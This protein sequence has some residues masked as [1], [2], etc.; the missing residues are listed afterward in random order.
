MPPGFT[1]NLRGITYCPEAAI[2]AAAQKLGPR[3]AGDARAARPR[4][5]SAPPTSPPA[6]AATPSTRSARCTWPG[7]FKGAPLSLVAITPA[8]AGPYDYGVVVVRVALHVD[9]LDRPGQRGLRHGAARSSAASRSGCA[10]SR[11]TSTSRNFTINPTNCSPVLG[12]LAGDRRPGDGHRLLAPTS[13]SST[14]HR[15][16]SSRR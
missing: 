9:P 7:P 1:G 13:R 16:P 6:P 10:R 14:A 15:C 11:S 12:R 3:R 8:L 4:A 2:A 5:R